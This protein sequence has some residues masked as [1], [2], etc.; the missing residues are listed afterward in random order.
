MKNVLAVVG[1]TASGKTSLA[2]AL[3]E[4]LDTEIVSADSMQIYRGMEIGTAV[5]SQEERRRVKHHLI[6]FLDP[7][8]HFSAGQ[9]QRAARAIVADLNARGKTAVAVGGSG[10]YVR[11]LVDGLFEGPAKDPATRD[12]LTEQARDHGVD[13]LYARLKETDGA[14]AAAIH[15]GDLRRIVRALEVYEITGKPLSL[16]HQQH[17]A[18]LKS[19]DTL[20]VALDY[21]RAVLY[22]RIDRRAED[23]IE[24][25][26][27]D[28]LRVLLDKGCGPEL[29]RIRSLGYREFMAYLRGEATFEEAFENMKRNTRHFAKR[30]LAWFR[31]DKRIHWLPADGDTPPASHADAVLHLLE[32]ASPS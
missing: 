27:L 15:P 14:Y 10:L 17:Q 31:A 8:E 2:I 25:G 18:Q 29:E 23:M 28:E 24:R 9:Y 22:H 6:G 4:R 1:P 3:A 11:A 19:L 16:L 30:Q 13:A 7:G 21:P 32:G 20:Q 26:F 5:P 12:R